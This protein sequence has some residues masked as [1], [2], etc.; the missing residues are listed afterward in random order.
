M[1]TVKHVM[2]DLVDFLVISFLFAT[3]VASAKTR[4]EH[5]R[6]RAPTAR[7]RVPTARARATAA[8]DARDPRVRRADATIARTGVRAMPGAA[9][10]RFELPFPP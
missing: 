5:A 10:S 9:P 3:G 7:T 1:N 4:L 6:T 8:E 2:R